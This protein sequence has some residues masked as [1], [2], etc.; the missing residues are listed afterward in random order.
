M[1]CSFSENNAFLYYSDNNRTSATVITVVA[2]EMKKVQLH[3]TQIGSK[4]TVRVEQAALQ[5]SFTY[6]VVP[7]LIPGPGYHLKQHHHQHLSY[8]IPHFQKNIKV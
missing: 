6:D 8:I 5:V 2:E 1:K 3:F 7:S 4:M